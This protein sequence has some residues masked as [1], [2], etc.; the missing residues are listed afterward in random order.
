MKNIFTLYNFVL[1]FLASVNGFLT[2]VVYTNLSGA[3]E[4]QGL[5]A[6]TIVL[7]N[8]VLGLFIFL[9]ISI[10]IAYF[11]NRKIVLILNW[12]LLLLLIIYIS[13]G[14]IKLN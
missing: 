1:V 7:A 13:I 12:T 3:A 6:G 9:I 4:N 2:G 8:G 10:V 5:A 11:S 14:V